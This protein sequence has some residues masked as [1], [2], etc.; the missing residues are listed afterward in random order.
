MY[1]IYVDIK[2]TISCNSREHQFISHPGT[3]F[4]EMGQVTK[5]TGNTRKLLS[6]LIIMKALIYWSGQALSWFV[7]IVFLMSMNCK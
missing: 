6:Q 4:P 5:M 2:E 7:S 1:L 3:Y